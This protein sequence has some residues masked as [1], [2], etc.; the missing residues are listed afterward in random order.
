MQLIKLNTLGLTFGG[1]WLKKGE[2]IPSPVPDMA[3][4][5]NTNP[6][7]WNGYYLTWNTP[8]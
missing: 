6:L 4:L 7:Q 3:L 8:N 5:W 1:R 2:Y